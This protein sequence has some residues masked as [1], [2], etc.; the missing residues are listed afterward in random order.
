M[1]IATKMPRNRFAVVAGSPSPCEVWMTR[2]SSAASAALGRCD[3]VSVSRRDGRSLASARRSNGTARLTSA[4]HGV[5]HR[6]ARSANAPPQ[7]NREHRQKCHVDGAFLAFRENRLCFTPESGHRIVSHCG[8]GAARSLTTDNRAYRN[9][10]PHHV[11][12]SKPSV[13]QSHNQPR[14]C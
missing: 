4:V 7:T 13:Y 14:A 9:Q 10:P 1:H 6:V 12:G 5:A 3:P 11:G 2:P 8:R